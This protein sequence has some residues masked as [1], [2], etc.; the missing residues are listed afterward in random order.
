MDI[1]NLEQKQALRTEQEEMSKLSTLFQQKTETMRNEPLFRFA[2]ALTYGLQGLSIA[3][4]SGVLFACY[5]HFPSTFLFVAPVAL[6][7]LVVIEMGKRKSIKEWN[8]SRL[9]DSKPSKIAFVGMLLFTAL[10]IYF[11]CTF[12]APAVDGASSAPLLLNVQSI[13]DSSLQSLQAS[14]LPLQS[15]KDRLVK[16]KEQIAKNG[17]KYDRVLKKTRYRTSALK[18][19]RLAERNIKAIDNKIQAITDASVLSMG[20]AIQNAQKANESVLNNH[21]SRNSSLSSVLGIVAFLVDVLL[22]GLSFF[23]YSHL[24][25]KSLELKDKYSD[26]QKEDVQIA[27]EP[28]KIERKERVKI[29]DA[30]TQRSTVAGFAGPR[31]GDMVDGK[32]CIAVKAGPKRGTLKKYDKRALQNLIN[33]SSANRAKELKPLLTK[34]E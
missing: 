22:C 14:L 31:H 30:E 21:K 29:Q 11:S 25:N 3:L 12:T 32:V 4:A 27:K 13:K 8:V 10:S 16:S 28:V 33:N 6:A 23:C 24:Y 34:F 5:N 18:D 1:Q 26:V 20:K 9:A 15:E 19:I 17:Q 2:S 7:I